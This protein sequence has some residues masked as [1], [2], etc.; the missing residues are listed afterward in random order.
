MFVHQWFEKQAALTPDAIAVRSG[1]ESLTYDELN[2]RANRLAWRLREMGV[3]PNSPVVICLERSLDLVTSIFGVLKAGGAYVPLDPSYPDASLIVMAE[4]S[5]AEIAICAPEKKP[6]F[7]ATFG[8]L[9]ESP[10]IAAGGEDLPSDN[11]PLVNQPDDLFYVIFT[12]GST[13][14]P[15][16][17]G[18]CHRGFAN[19][20]NWFIE[21]FGIG[22]A[23][24]SLLISSFSFDLTQKNYFAALSRGGQLHLAPSGPYDPESLTLA[25]QRA[26]ITLINCTPSAAYPLAESRSDEQIQRLRSLRCVFL[27]GE[28]ISAARFRSWTGSRWFHAEIVN[29]YGPTECTDICAFHRLTASELSEGAAVPVGHP[30]D[31]VSVAVIDEHFEECPAGETGE[32]WIS[33]AGVGAG[34]L[35]DPKRTAEKFL[36]NPVPHILNGPVVYRTGD[37]ARRRADGSVEFAGRV[38]HQVKIRGFRVEIG[39]IEAAIE[40]HPEIKESAVVAREAGEGSPV[41]LA[42]YFVSRSGCN[43]TADDLRGFLRQRLPEHMV[44]AVFR[45]LT[46]LPLSSNGKVDRIALRDMRTAEPAAPVVSAADG[47]DA[48]I[49]KIWCEVLRV[50]DVSPDQNFFDLG[51]D[52]LLLVE[53]HNRINKLLPGEKVSIT[54]LFQYPTISSLSSSLQ[55]TSLEKVQP[56]S[57]IAA[58]SCAER[59]EARDDAAERARKQREAMTRRFTR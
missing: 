38:D 46:A 31:N 4:D 43:L 15:K 13:G 5:G 58:N 45:Q 20:M 37:M 11:P 12:S 21:E 36:S 50:P 54:A 39:E 7:S 2:L 32:L 19:L 51:G 22:P 26:G 14:R 24:R 47:V 9:I 41:S 48:S 56:V 42:A 25:I 34:Y 35:K 33:G 57:S 8:H 23:D 1:E 10:R 29:T 44:P 28:P 27:G 3:L 40:R 59:P 30:I 52:S 55:K 18:V 16:G 6:I 53:V 17:A 49:A